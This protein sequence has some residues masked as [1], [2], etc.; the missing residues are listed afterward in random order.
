[1]YVANTYTHFSDSRN[2]S[3]DAKKI[4]LKLLSLLQRILVSQWDLNQ[5]KIARGIVDYF[6][7]V[8]IGKM[9]GSILPLILPPEDMCQVI[10]LL[11][12]VYYM[13]TL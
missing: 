9:Q 1:M 3:P 11:S 4:R 6:I 5:E 13:H 8:F 10:D 2:T 12:S 7:R